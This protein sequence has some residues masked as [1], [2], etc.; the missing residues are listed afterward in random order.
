MASI[1][2]SCT[3]QQVHCSSAVCILQILWSSGCCW[4]N[5]IGCACLCC[6]C[7]CAGFAAAWQLSSCRMQDSS[8]SDSGRVFWAGKSRPWLTLCTL[9]TFSQSL[10]GHRAALAVYIN[11]GLPQQLRTSTNPRVGQCPAV[12][13][14]LQPDA[15]WW[16]WCA[17][18][19]AIAHVADTTAGMP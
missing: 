17:P 8:Q 1:Q 11:H 10:P 2:L 4:S 18:A 13:H 5:G 19:A 9:A 16:L 14:A 7:L 6:S 15:R 12:A 3:A